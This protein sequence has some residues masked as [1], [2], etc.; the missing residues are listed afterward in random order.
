MRRLG[1]GLA[2]C[3][4]ALLVV[5]GCVKRTSPADPAEPEAGTQPSA[6]QAQDDA[7]APSDDVFAP[8]ENAVER[9]RG[10]QDTVDAQAERLRKEIE[11]AEGGDN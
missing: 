5:T 1:V 4:F 9:A 8:L 11:K 10:V 6:A 7:A 3:G 2:S